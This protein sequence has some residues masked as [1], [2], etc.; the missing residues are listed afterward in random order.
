MVA[1]L[2]DKVLVGKAHYQLVEEGPPSVLKNVLALSPSELTWWCPMVE[3]LVV[4]APPKLHS[5]WVQVVYVV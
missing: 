1:V 3:T 2:V 5:Q 4:L